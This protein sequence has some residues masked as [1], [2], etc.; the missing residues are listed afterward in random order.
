MKVNIQ[1]MKSKFMKKE[2]NPG[3]KR[4]ID[5]AISELNTGNGGCTVTMF[6]YIDGDPNS[7]KVIFLN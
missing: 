7:E 3:I 5:A 2:R 4:A 1:L 6:V